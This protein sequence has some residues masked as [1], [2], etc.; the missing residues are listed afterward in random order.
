MKHPGWPMPYAD[1]LRL[2]IGRLCS[3][4]RTVEIR[5]HYLRQFLAWWNERLL[6]YDHMRDVVRSYTFPPMTEGDWTPESII[7][8]LRRSGLPEA[9]S[10]AWQMLLNLWWDGRLTRRAKIAI[11]ARWERK[12]RNV[13]QERSK[14]SPSIEKHSPSI[15][16]GSPSI[17]KSSPSIRKHIIGRCLRKRK[18]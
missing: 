16:K 17:N 4:A 11:N 13:N 9:Q 18:A 7:R 15:R 1:F 8:A 14:S 12:R 6:T 3:R 5:E 10:H 2:Y